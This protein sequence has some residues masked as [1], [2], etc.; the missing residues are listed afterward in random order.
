MTAG[1]IINVYENCIA[2]LNTAPLDN[3]IRLFCDVPPVFGGFFR[4]RMFET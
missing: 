2:I 4:G 3:W 1:R